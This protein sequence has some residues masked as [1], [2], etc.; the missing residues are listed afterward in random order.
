MKLLQPGRTWR[1][2]AA[3][4]G[5]EIPLEDLRRQINLLKR[6]LNDERI[7]LPPRAQE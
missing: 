4:L 6:L 7:A 1:G 3:D 2:I 5:L